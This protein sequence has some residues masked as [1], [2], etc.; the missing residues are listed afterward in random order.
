MAAGFV[1]EVT[2]RIS[3]LWRSPVALVLAATLLI[4]I[5]TACAGIAQPQGWSGPVPADGVILVSHKGEL[6]ALELQEGA[7]SALESWSFPA[8]ED[9]DLDL[10]GIYG[11]PAVAD[12][13]VYFGAYD[14][15]VYALDL[16][17]GRPLWAVATDGP[18]IGGIALGGGIVYVGSDDGNLYALDLETGDEKG[19]CLTGDGIWATPLVADGTVYVASL[20][21]KLY[22]FDAASLSRGDCQP[23]WEPFEAEGGLIS[24]PVLAGDTILVGGIDRRLYAV[25]AATGQEKWSFKADNWFWTRPLVA[26]GVVYA[27]SVDSNVYALDLAAGEPKW[28]VPFEAEAPIR[29][30][31]II[32]DSVLIVA[33]RNG[34]LYGLDPATGNRRWGDPESDPV[35][36][37]GKVLGHPILFMDEVLISTQGRDLFLIDSRGGKRRLEVLRET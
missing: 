5:A 15:N 23:R 12:G 32:L 33:D 21:D 8:K 35:E 30:A 4:I 6:S 36:V 34:N 1:R 13:T 10:E 24:T 18:V 37:G 29:A 11:N 26:D 22:A 28:D 25:D 3:E 27:G 17:D 2:I 19:R 16:E 20:D 7:L 9:K 31:P 14:D